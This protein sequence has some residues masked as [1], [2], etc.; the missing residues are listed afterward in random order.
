MLAFLE[1]PDLVLVALVVLLVFGGSRLPQLARSL[2]QAQ[3]EFRDAMK[4]DDGTAADAGP[5]ST[6]PPDTKG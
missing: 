2:G 1:G 3:R 6:D 5:P 4:P